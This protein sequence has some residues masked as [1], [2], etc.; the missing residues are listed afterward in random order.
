[1]EKEDF[2]VIWNLQEGTDISLGSI[3]DVDE[4]FGSVAHFHDTKTSSIVVH[5]LLGALGE[6]LFG[7]DTWSS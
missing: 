3:R 1:M 5:H 4:L 7:K 2:E 6:N